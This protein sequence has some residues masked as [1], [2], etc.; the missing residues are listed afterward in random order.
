MCGLWIYG[1]GV[2]GGREEEEVLL[3]GIERDGADEMLVFIEL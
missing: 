1:R 2:R 3:V